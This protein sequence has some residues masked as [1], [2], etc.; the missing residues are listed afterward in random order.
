HRPVFRPGPDGGG[1]DVVVRGRRAVRRR[2]VA[3]A[4]APSSRYAVLMLRLPRRRRLLLLL[5]AVPVLLAGWLWWQVGRDGTL[6]H[7]NFRRLRAG[8]TEREVETILGRPNRP[9]WHF[10]EVNN[11]SASPEYMAEWQTNV[12]RGFV[13]T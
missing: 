8:M 12:G 2:G 7:K 3:L 6:S 13:C 11:V 9:P 10:V 5:L 4:P 1:G